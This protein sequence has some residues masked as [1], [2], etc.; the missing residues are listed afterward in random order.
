MNHLDFIIAFES[1]QASEEEII[2]GFQ[3]LIDDG[4]IWH[5]QG[6]YQRVAHTLIESGECHN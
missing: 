5:L 2:A 4:T 6:T 3:A 1:G